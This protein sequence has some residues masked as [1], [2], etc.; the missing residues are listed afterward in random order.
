MSFSEVFMMRV[1]C[2]PLFAR[3]VP[4]DLKVFKRLHAS[5]L[6]FFLIFRPLSFDGRSSACGSAVSRNRENSGAVNADREFQPRMNANG[7]EFGGIGPGSSARIRVHS[8]SF[9]VKNLA[10]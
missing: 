9:A 4:S 10:C 8:R 1:S 6:N 3:A 7:R 5:E 2:A